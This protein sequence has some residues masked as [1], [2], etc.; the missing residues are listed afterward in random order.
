MKTSIPVY[1]ILFIVTFLVRLPSFFFSVFDWDE[2][3]FIIM[4]QSI[5]EG[6][7][8]YVEV[9]DIKPPGAFYVYSFFILLFGKS[10][11]AIRLGGMLCIFAASVLLFETGKALHDRKAGITGALFLIVFASS[12]YSGLSTMI[13][14]ILLV[15]VCLILFLLFTRPMNNALSFLMGLTLGLGILM[16]TN[17]LFE[18][19]A[20]AV[21]LSFGHLEPKMRFSNRIRKLTILAAGITLPLLAAISYFFS[22]DALPLFIDTNVTALLKYAGAG[23]LSL[24]ARSFTLLANIMKN[25]VHGDILLWACFLLGFIYLI[26]MKIPA[27]NVG[28]RSLTIVFFSAQIISLFVSGKSFGYHYLILT[29]PIMSIVSGV[30]LSHW[31]SVIRVKKKIHYILTLTLIGAGLFYA[32]QEFIGPRYIQVISRLYHRDTLVDDSCYRVARYLDEKNVRGKYIYMANRCQIAY[33]LTGAKHPTKYIHP[34]NLLF[35]EYLL[36]A[37]DGED[38]TGEKELMKILGRKPLFIV[39]KRELWPQP[40]E[41]YK[42]ILER[43]LTGK[44]ELVKIIDTYYHIYRRR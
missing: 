1:F 36:K 8:P 19:L 7:V 42:R 31:L 9:W 10:I 29:V 17:M 30:A 5:L 25:I 32:L 38:A 22:H 27:E 39:H 2:S 23:E 16:K 44:Y 35:K 13:E 28:F 11:F 21:L 37:I 40:G 6:N 4:A 14:H 34:T 18:S 41:N 15:P 20:V 24:P 26:G 43:V 33:W 3:T 12:G